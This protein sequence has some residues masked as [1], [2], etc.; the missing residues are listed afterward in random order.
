MIEFVK[1]DP[2][3][4]LNQAVARYEAVSGETLYPGDEHYMFL[5]QMVQMIVACKADINSSANQ[6]LLQ[7]CTGTILN[8]YG[9]Q[10][11]VTRIA[12]QTASAAI[13]FTV[14]AA[15]GFNVTVPANTRV[16]PDGQLVFYLQ[17]AVV[18]PAGQTS[19]EGNIFAEQAGAVYN[20]FLPGQ[21]QSLIDPVDYIATVS[22]TTASA[23]GADEEDD[24]SYR[25]R[26]RQSW[27]AIS[28]AGSKESYEYWA[29]TASQDIADAEAVR[30]NP[31][32]VT[33]Y[34]LM[35]GAAV[36]TQAI[37]DDVSAVCSAEKHRPLTD[38]VFISA[39]QEKSYDIN[40]TYYISKNRSTEVSAIQRAV[41]QAVSDFIAAQKKQL[42]GNLNPD[43]LRKV[44]LAAGV[45]RADITAP[46]YT[47]LGSKEVAVAGSQT[48]AYGGVL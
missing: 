17:S 47:A 10:Y 4:L 32:E 46:V 19:A 39:A 36:P 35:N 11:D 41:N 29:K 21:I 1:Y 20:G 2:E 30:T 8:G 45:Y 7:Y 25:E 13:K 44:L 24:D 9:E 33:V 3:D 26:I 16:T 34:I 40:F 5:S 43:D 48:V 38:N 22:N 14:S 15:L 18:I 28:T 12:A 31:G 42:G 23:G 27:E 6:N 37:L